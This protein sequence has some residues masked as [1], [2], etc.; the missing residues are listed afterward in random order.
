[1]LGLQIIGEVSDGLEAVREA[2]ELQ[3]DLIGPRMERFS[4]VVYDGEPS[5]WD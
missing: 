1:M 2:E 4:Y 3:P 5:I